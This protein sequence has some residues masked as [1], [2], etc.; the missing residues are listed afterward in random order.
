MI[1]DA[2]L[3]VDPSMNFAGAAV[4]STVLP[5]NAISHSQIRDM[6]EGRQ[7][8]FVV[9]VLEA[10][11]SANATAGVN[12]EIT[13]YNDGGAD[14]QFFKVGTTYLKSQLTVQN[15]QKVPGTQSRATQI[16]LPVPPLW[17]APTGIAG[18]PAVRRGWKFMSLIGIPVDPNVSVGPPPQPVFSTGRVSIDMALDFGD[19]LKTYPAS[20]VMI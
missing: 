17:G 19:S 11:T 4:N 5:L 8:Y 3:Q 20:T 2:F 18:D 16:I 6:G 13:V 10:F 7:L 1:S 15:D 12:F 9:T 14:T